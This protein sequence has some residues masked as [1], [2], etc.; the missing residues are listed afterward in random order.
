MVLFYHL[1]CCLLFLK[2]HPSA[3]T[4]FA[5]SCSL[6]INISGLPF[7]LINWW[8]MLLEAW[9]QRT[10]I[11]LLKIWRFSGMNFVSNSSN[12]FAC[13]SA[14]LWGLNY[15]CRRFS[16]EELPYA[17][18]I[19]SCTQT[20]G[21]VAHWQGNMFLLQSLDFVTQIMWSRYFVK[22]KCLLWRRCCVDFC[23]FFCRPS[24]LSKSQ[25]F[26]RGMIL[27]I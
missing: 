23:F 2:C 21:F 9:I 17:C 12:V 11:N 26:L 20:H 3:D 6:W 13:C 19:H 10:G 27:E 14:L 16:F 15:T 1:L 7:V 24:L 5:S 4:F 18:F 22:P 25:K 8:Q